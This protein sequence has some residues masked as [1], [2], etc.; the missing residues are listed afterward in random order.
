MADNLDIEE[1]KRSASP[2]ATIKIYDYYEFVDAYGEV[3]DVPT[4]GGDEDYVV[5]LERDELRDPY[6]FAHWW[7]EQM[8]MFLDCPQDPAEFE[9]RGK[10]AWVTHHA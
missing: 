2:I 4:F 6:G 8:A 9:W 5:V 3:D 10:P 7:A 1:A